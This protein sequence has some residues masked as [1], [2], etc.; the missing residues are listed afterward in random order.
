MAEGSSPEENPQEKPIKSGESISDSAK[1]QAEKATILEDELKDLPP[2]AQRIVRS[3]IFS[4]SRYMGPMPN[5]IAGKINEKH[6]DKILEGSEK[7]SERS[8]KGSI[9]QKYF[10]AFI[11]LVFVG[12]FIFLTIWLS[13]TN[14]DLY[15][16]ILKILVGFLGGLGSGYGIKAYQDKD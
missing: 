13:G 14:K 10:V 8:F 11:I 12:L 15:M 9:H 2:E 16:D 3:M 7:D 1:E 4:Q 5:P 6:I